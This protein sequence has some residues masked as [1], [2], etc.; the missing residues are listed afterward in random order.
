MGLIVFYRIRFAVQKH[1][2]RLTKMLLIA[3]GFYVAVTTRLKCM[4]KTKPSGCCIGIS[5]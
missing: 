1:T 4:L 5:G 3:R 2:L